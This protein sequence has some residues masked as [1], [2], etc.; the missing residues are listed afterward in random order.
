MLNLVGRNLRHWL[1]FYPLREILYGDH[2]VLHLPYR[3]RER[4]QYIDSPGMERPR[5]VNRYELFWW[6]FVP[7]S[8]SL[9]LL[10][11]LYVPRAVFPYGW[12]IVSH[13]NGLRC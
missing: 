10:A 9:T 12:P 4:S 11:L 5:A 13:T 7:I 3:Q 1:G 8:V 6:R 2:E